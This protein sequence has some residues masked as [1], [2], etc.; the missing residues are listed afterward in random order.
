MYDPRTN[1]AND[2]SRRSCSSTSATRSTD[3]GAAQRAPWPRA[4]SHG[5]PVIGY[6]PL[7]SRRQPTWRWPARCCAGTTAGSCRSVSEQLF[8][9]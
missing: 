8:S 9:G 3:H 1:L 4:P 2:W 6:D 5:L 7:S